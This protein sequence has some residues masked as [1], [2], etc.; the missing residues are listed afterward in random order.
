MDS[1]VARAGAHRGGVR[2]AESRLLGRRGGLLPRLLAVLH[3]GWA[4]R[5]QA[6][7]STGRP[8]H[9]H[10]G[11]DR[12]PHV[13]RAA[14]SRVP[15][16]SVRATLHQPGQTV[17]PG[18]APE[19]WISRAV[20]RA[21]SRRSSRTRSPCPGD[22]RASAAV[23]SRAPQAARAPAS[24]VAGQEQRTLRP[25]P[26][27]IAVDGQPGWRAVSALERSVPPP[28][29]RAS[30]NVELRTAVSGVGAGPHGRQPAWRSRGTL[31]LRGRKLL[32]RAVVPAAALH[33][34]AGWVRLFV[35]APRGGR[36]AHP[37]V[38]RRGRPA[39]AQLLHFRRGRRAGRTAGTR[40]DAPPWLLARRVR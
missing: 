12:L 11:L 38:H 9:P 8:R 13:A 17:L 23:E 5:R 6:V 28:G 14:R 37:P 25:G 15:R 16:F 31:V 21:G 19:T 32:D 30:R 29:S 4:Q 33:A 3:G 18:P 34:P 7:G 20:R 24:R 40:R 36:T 22:R 27:R 39:V 10:G 35:G 1:A 2:F 26:L